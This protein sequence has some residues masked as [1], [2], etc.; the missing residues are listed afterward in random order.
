MHPPS[1]AL[2]PASLWN[3]SS[4]F[5]PQ[6]TAVGLESPDTHPTQGLLGPALQPLVPLYPPQGLSLCK[7]QKPWLFSCTLRSWDISTL[8]S[9]QTSDTSAVVFPEG[10]RPGFSPNTRIHILSRESKGRILEGQW[11]EKEHSL[12]VVSEPGF[13]WWASMLGSP[14]VNYTVGT[15]PWLQLG[16]RCPPLFLLT[17]IWEEFSSF[18]AGLRL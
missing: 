15:S 14:Q 2:C 16:V 18:S 1:P 13:A 6:K 10:P 17:V 12:K 8:A 11:E 3:L 7:E 9:A 5:Y 4:F